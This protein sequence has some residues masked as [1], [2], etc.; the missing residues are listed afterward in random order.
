MSTK[1]I[2]ERIHQVDAKKG[3]VL[4]RYYS[5]IHRVLAEAFRVLKPGKAA[6]FVVGTSNMRGIDSQTQICL[7]E[8]GVSLGFDLVGIG[9]RQLDRDRR[10]MPARLQKSASQ[11]EERMH[12]EYVVAFIKPER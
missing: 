4:H 11:I 8:I 1:N 2:V 7:G 10:M 5:E 12:E 6:I 3:L 9:T